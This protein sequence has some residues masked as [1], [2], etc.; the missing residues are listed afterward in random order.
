MSSNDQTLSSLLSD[1]LFSLDGAVFGAITAAASINSFLSY[2][3]TSSAVRKIR[4]APSVKVSDLRFLI[5]DVSQPSDAAKLVVLRGCVQAKP[6]ADAIFKSLKSSAIVNPETSEKTFIDAVIVERTQR[7]I[8]DEWM[9]LFGL[10]YDL[11]GRL[12]K[13][14]SPSESS[15]MKSVPFVLGETGSSDFVVPNLSGSSHPLP[16]VTVYQQKQLFNLNPY[17]FLQRVLFHD[18]PIGLLDEEKV[19]P[20]GVEVSAVGICNFQNG[21]PEIKSCSDLPC[22][23]SLL[24]KDELVLYLESKSNARFWVGVGFGLLSVGILCYAA[25]R[26]WHKL[27][28]WRQQM[29]QSQ[30]QQ[31]SDAAE[32][33]AALQF[34]AEDVEDEEDGDVFDGQLCVICLTRR[35]RSAF[36]PC[37]HLVCCHLCCI[38]VER[39]TS[40]KCPVCRQEIRTAIRIY[41]S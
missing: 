2:K 34:E 7:L 39:S 40:P 41:D 6:G 18:H 27:K 31:E 30:E 38:S 16:L 11:K 20:V 14:F 12:L 19:L 17:T 29:Q 25:V 32:T 22:F 15:T 8:Y 4:E 36:I 3:S 23:M 37:G 1:L 33:I 21:A 35:R 28:E 13:M 24:D 9:S 10:T 5:P 26:N